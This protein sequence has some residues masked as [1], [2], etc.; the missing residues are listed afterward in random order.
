MGGWGLHT[1]TENLTKMGLFM[2]QKGE[3]N[4]KRLLGEAW[5]NRAMTP[6]IKQKPDKNDPDDDWNQGYCY[7][8]WAC[9]HGAV[10]MHGSH[11]QMVI[12]IS[13]KNAVVTTTANVG[14]KAELLNDIWKYIYEE[15]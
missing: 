9:S 5:F 6:H 12:I 2:L 11:T 1:T 13:D 4:G 8:M 15:L 14:K 10:R 7:Q 3:W